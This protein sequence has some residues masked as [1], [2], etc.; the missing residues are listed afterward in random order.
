MANR[1]SIA[2]GESR[3]VS[4]DEM[5]PSTQSPRLGTIHQS[6]PG[7]EEGKKKG[8][9]TS[10]SGFQGQTERS[11]IVTLKRCKKS[12]FGCKP[13]LVSSVY[14]SQSKTWGY[15]TVEHQKGATDCNTPKSVW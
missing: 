9:A 6:F 2:C 11:R 12:R 3:E 10:E 5:T 1:V 7:S 4:R 13:S 15:I 8:G 14:N